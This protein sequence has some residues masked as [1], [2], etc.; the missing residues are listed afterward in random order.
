MAKTKSYRI[1]MDAPT[2]PPV[3]FNEHEKTWSYADCDWEHC[4]TLAAAKAVIIK[5]GNPDVIIVGE[6]LNDR[7][8]WDK[9]FKWLEH[10]KRRPEFSLGALPM[11]WIRNKVC[12]DFN[13]KFY[14]RNYDG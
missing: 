4:K 13:A 10:P 8:G 7:A 5:R 9:F 3:N 6:H 11:A 1:W 14:S 12:E 2:S